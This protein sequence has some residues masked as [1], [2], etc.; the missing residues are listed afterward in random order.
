[1]VG[2]RILS[3]CLLLA[4]LATQGLLCAPASAAAS[5]HCVQRASA[6]AHDCCQPS[7]RMDCCAAPDRDAPAIPSQSQTPP[8]RVG[9]GSLVPLAMSAPGA[10][11]VLQAPMPCGLFRAAP[12]HGYRSTD[13]PI[14]NAVF[15]L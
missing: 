6:P 9:A 3:A 5:P 2:R 14:L 11:P 15:L 13:I 10:T 1:M 4:F 12:V 8:A 7:D